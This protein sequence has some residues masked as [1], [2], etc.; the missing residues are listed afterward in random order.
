MA[1]NITTTK[2]KTEVLMPDEDRKI[3]RQLYVLRSY[4]GFEEPVRRY[5]MNFL[6][7]IGI[8]Y[9][10]YNGNV[11]G[12]NF[13]GAPLFSA[14]M[15]MVNTDSWK[16]RGQADALEDGYV[17]TI[18]AD[19]NIRL[20]RDKEKKNQTSLGADDKNG[21][22][23][24]LNLLRNGAQINF[25]FCHSEEVGGTGSS[26]IMQDTELV[27]FIAGCQYGVVI[28][29]RNA[30]DI[31]G[32]E[33]KYCMALD[34]R[35]AD[36]AS[37]I[38]Y[39]FKPEKGLCSDAD[40]FCK[41]LECVNLSCG[42]YEP[43]RSTEY[44][45]LNELW[46]TY[47][48]CQAMLND[49]DYH[50]VSRSRMAKFT[51]STTSYSSSYYGNSSYSSYRSGYSTAKSSSY[52]S[53]TEETKKE[54][55]EKK[56]SG[57]TRTTTKT[58][59][60]GND[61]TDAATT[62]SNDEMWELYDYGFIHEDNSPDWTIMTYTDDTLP[63]GTQVYDVVANFECPHCN[64]EVMVTQADIDAV[65]MDGYDVDKDKLYGVCGDCYQKMD[66]REMHGLLR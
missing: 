62:I 19:T 17:F 48:F 21:I 47:L 55:D 43:H 36:F 65:L 11:L 5:I 46:T 64:K 37:R 33:N 31:I 41:V 60:N 51:S 45:N 66:L 59:I 61:T 9:I 8:P 28:D 1:I 16:L 3:L 52:L 26:Q 39:K 13:P 6:D 24:I 29:R 44:T 12:F 27:N 50:S 20:Y 15:D 56:S 30:W 22:W 34:D 40:K 58:S 4:S 23:V 2:E 49:F 14:H 18:D 32:Y 7:N 35:L 25:A 10:N 38:G 63:Q 54:T 53:K 42:Y 57:V